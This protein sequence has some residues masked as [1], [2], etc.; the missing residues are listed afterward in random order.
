M[1]RSKKNCNPEADK[2]VTNTIMNLESQLQSN[3]KWANFRGICME[4][5]PEWED[6]NLMCAH[7]HLKGYCFSNCKSV[8]SHVGKEEVPAATGAVYEEYLSEVGGL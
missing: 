5:R 7:L 4:C 8:A 6:G 2:R 1:P 3:K